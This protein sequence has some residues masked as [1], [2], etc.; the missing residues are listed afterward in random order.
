MFNPNTMKTL[1]IDRNELI[2]GM[3]DIEDMVALSIKEDLGAKKCT[4]NCQ[5]RN[6]QG[7]TIWNFKVY[8]DGLKL[9]AMCE[10]SPYDLEV[11]PWNFPCEL[12][13]ILAD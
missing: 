3:C 6:W 11:D 1:Q 13:Y 9:I 2:D 8:A 5:N 4:A 7:S 10:I 12:S